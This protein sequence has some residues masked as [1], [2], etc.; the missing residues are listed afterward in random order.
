MSAGNYRQDDYEA[1]L[2]MAE[3]WSDEPLPHLGVLADPAD[4]PEQARVEAE[5]QMS[6]IRQEASA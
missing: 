2:W 6:V 4:D 5:Q 1:L 3:A